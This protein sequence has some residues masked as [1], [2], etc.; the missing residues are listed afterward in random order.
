VITERV[1]DEGNVVTAGGV[2][3]G[4]DLGLHLVERFAGP[5]ARARV[6]KQMDYPYSWQRGR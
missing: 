6:A 1:V 4:I 3:A 5:E 2:T